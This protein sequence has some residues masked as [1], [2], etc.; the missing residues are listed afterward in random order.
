[1]LELASATE[2]GLTSPH[3]RCCSQPSACSS[4]SPPADPADGSTQAMEQA[5]RGA[6]GRDVQVAVRSASEGASDESLVATAS[7]EHAA[8]LVVIAWS[9]R[10]RR[11]TLR[12]VKPADGRW[13]DREIRFDSA[14][15]ATERGR[16]VGFALASM[17][18][19]D[20]L[21]PPDRPSAPA[22]APAPAPA[23]LRLR[24][25]RRA[26]ARRAAPRGSRSTVRPRS[27]PARARGRGARRHRA[28]RI[29]RRPRRS[30]R[31]SRADRRRARAARRR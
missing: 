12:V 22:P 11:A 13:T 29:W 9:E 30:L 16:T 18:P 5:L 17:V 23:A 21:A 2:L 14:D 19:D 24:P 3:R 10:P 4:S 7:N 27:E 28:R 8:L 20:A 25:R 6:L 26:R 31:R 1:M 15:V